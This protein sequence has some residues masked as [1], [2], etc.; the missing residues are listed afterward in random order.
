MNEVIDLLKYRAALL[1]VYK[2]LKQCSPT[3]SVSDKMYRV[4]RQTELALIYSCYYVIHI[5]GPNPEID[6]KI[7]SLKKFYRYGEI[8]NIDKFPPSGYKKP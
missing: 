1:G 3:E 4:S 7:E 2:V 5:E 6:K 8:L